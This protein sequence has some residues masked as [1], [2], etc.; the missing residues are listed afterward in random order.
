[1]SA[2]YPDRC[3][4]CEKAVEICHDDGYGYE[5]GE[6]HQQECEHC[7]KTF[8]YTTCIDINHD[9]EKADCLNGEALHQYQR[10]ATYPEQFARMRCAVCGEERPLTDEEK[11][12]VRHD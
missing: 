6:K 5:E 1:M 12:E 3:P 9:L 10:T 8:I 4:Y 7:G 2:L 11:Q